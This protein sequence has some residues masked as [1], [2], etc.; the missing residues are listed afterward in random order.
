MNSFSKEKYTK[1]D[2]EEFVLK[3]VNYAKNYGITHALKEFMNPKGEFI[4]G[5]HGE[6]YIF[7]FDFKGNVLAHGDKPKLVGVNLFHLKDPE[8]NY[9]IQKLINAVNSKDHWIKYIWINP[10]D[11]KIEKKYGFCL[12]VDDTWWIGS[13]L[14]E[15][16]DT[17]K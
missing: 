4:K 7:A 3:A 16:E 12:K 5:E 1:K 17:K 11:K 10:A 14:Y 2:I 13:G 9:P 6:L 8:G 15:T